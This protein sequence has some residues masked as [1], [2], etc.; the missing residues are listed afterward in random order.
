MLA[1]QLVVAAALSGCGSESDA[2]SNSS[3]PTKSTAP[4]T[5]NGAAAGSSNSESPPTSNAQF[6]G[7]VVL[8]DRSNYQYDVSYSLQLGPVETSIANDQPGM[9]SVVMTNAGTVT[10]EFN[11]PGRNPPT[12]SSDPFILE[13]GGL[14]EMT[15]AVCLAYGSPIEV[16]VTAPTAGDYCY[17]PLII[18]DGM[19]DLTVLRAQVGDDSVTTAVP[20][21]PESS[22]PQIAQDLAHPQIFV[23]KGANGSNDDTCVF[24]VGS[25]NGIIETSSQGQLVC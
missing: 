20:H 3:E 8:H 16:H 25:M 10:T 5:E 2:G 23:V 9:A 24:D 7:S 11:N 15:S 1:A 4:A 18:N 22:A 6:E 17:Y 14:Y 13:L 21:I 19:G 12:S